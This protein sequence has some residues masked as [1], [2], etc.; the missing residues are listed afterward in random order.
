MVAL[1]KLLALLTQQR[2]R[3]PQT[4]FRV[5]AFILFCLAGCILLLQDLNYITWDFHIVFNRKEEQKINY[6]GKI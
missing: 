1:R 6:A 3:L 5:I 4:Y 2:Q